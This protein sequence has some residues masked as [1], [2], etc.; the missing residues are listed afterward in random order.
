MAGT[1]TAAIIGAGMAGLA[2][3]R[4]LVDAGVDVSVIDKGRALGGRIATRRSAFGAFDHGAVALSA[5]DG[6]CEHAPYTAGYARYLEAAGAQGAAVFWPA[7]QGWIGLPGMSGIVNP[8][9]QGLTVKVATEVTGLAQ[10]AQGWTLQGDGVPEAVFDQVILAIPQPQALRL[11][12]AFPDL[13]HAIGAA[14]MRAVWTAMVR[15]DQGLPLQAGVF[16]RDAFHGEGTPIAQAIRNSAKPG[17]GDRGEAWV[18]HA[19]TDW[20]AAHLDLDKPV[21]ADLLLAAFFDSFGLDP[22]APVWLEGHRWRYG[23]TE[24]ALGSPFARDAQRGLAVCG[25]WCLGDSACDAFVS[26]SA[27]AVALLGH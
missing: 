2:C 21:A 3:A 6:A 7:A 16:R 4:V 24:Q 12:Q 8:L 14:R 27:L 15:F 10:T 19:A 18:L 20:T 9:A 23:L 17:R 25:D 22:L 1:G 5:T 26:G 11:L 13:Q